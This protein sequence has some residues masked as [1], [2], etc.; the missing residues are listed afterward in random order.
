MQACRIRHLLLRQPSE[1]FGPSLLALWKVVFEISH[2][3]TTTKL[4]ATKG[5]TFLVMLV[6]SSCGR[7]QEV[8]RARKVT[9][10]SKHYTCRHWCLIDITFHIF[11]SCWT[12]TYHPLKDNPKNNMAPIQ[13]RC[14]HGKDGK[15]GTIGV[16]SKIGHVDPT[17]SVMVEFKVLVIKSLTINTQTFIRTGKKK[18]K[19][20]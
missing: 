1:E 2:H 17:S 5:Q 12:I 8:V 4:L 13:P 19:I 11:V 6:Q 16:F 9:S 14:I 18:E 15:H 7:T 10:T 20:K 3:F